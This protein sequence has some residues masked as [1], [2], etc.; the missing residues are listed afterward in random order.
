[1]TLTNKTKFLTDADFLI[2]ML[3]KYSYQVLPM[4]YELHQPD[5]DTEEFRRQLKAF[6]FK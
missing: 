1:M 4:A 2:R 6:L 5:N 3:Y